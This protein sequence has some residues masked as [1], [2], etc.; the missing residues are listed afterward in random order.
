MKLTPTKTPFHARKAV[1]FHLSTLQTFDPAKPYTSSAP[2]RAKLSKR[3][4]LEKVEDQSSFASTY[5]IPDEDDKTV[6]GIDASSS[7]PVRYDVV[8]CQWCLQHLSDK[9]LVSFLVR[10]K[11]SL[12]SPTEHIASQ[13][14]D[15][16]VLDGSG[17]IV[18]KENVL[19]DEQDGG[20]KVWYDDEDHSITRTSNAYERVFKEAGLIIVRTQLQLG[21]PEELFPVRIW[22][23]RI[24]P[25][26]ASLESRIS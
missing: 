25:S 1:H 21:L 3:L 10:A 8:W 23:L 2:S 4:K 19:R 15:N 7:E 22:C 12:M 20:E 24:S 26:P 14:K 16:A 5:S 6:N 18:V 13:I 11:A 9:D 17:I